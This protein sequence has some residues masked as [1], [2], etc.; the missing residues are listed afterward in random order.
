MKRNFMLLVLA[1]IVA[2]F[3]ETAHAATAVAALPDSVY[4]LMADYGLGAMTWMLAILAAAGAWLMVRLS[5][6]ST[7]RALIVELGAHARD[8]VLEVWQVYVEA[9]KA[10]RSDGKLTPE[11]KETARQMA[12]EKLR[13]RL[14]LPKLIALGG[15]ALARVFHHDEWAQ[16]L[17]ELLGGAV[18]TAVGEAKRQGKAAGLKTSGTDARTAAPASVTVS[19]PR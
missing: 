4:G 15:G 12:V 3:G 2:A 16:K 11:E 10:A 14:S 6:A 1:T 5:L 8:V 17:E 19:F 9:L 7:W 13:A 18:E